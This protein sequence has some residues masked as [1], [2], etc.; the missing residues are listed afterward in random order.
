M[1]VA[2]A[3]AGVGP[4]ATGEPVEGREAGDDREGRRE[5]AEGI[6]LDCSAAFSDRCSMG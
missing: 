4:E 1:V 5:E 2:D 3:V 6:H